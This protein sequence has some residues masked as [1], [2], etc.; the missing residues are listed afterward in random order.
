MPNSESKKSCEELFSVVYRAL[1]DLAHRKMASEPPEH[2]L[3]PTAL[4]HE[5]YLRLKRSNRVN[6]ESPEYFFAAAAEAMRRILVERARHYSRIRHG[7]GF[8]RVDFNVVDVAV[9]ERGPE[10]LAVDSALSNLEAHDESKANLVKL[11]YFVGFTISE[12]AEILGYSPSKAKREWAYSR[13]W[14][15]REIKEHPN[16]TL[17]TGTEWTSINKQDSPNTSAKP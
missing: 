17:H 2:T 10:L 13:A 12:S 16:P 1:R 6:W 7:R 4:V 8:T 11:R 14:L 3:D 5:T 9:R 15:A